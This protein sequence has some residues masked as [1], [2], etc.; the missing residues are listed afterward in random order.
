MS[1]R[2]EHAC[3]RLFE[4]YGVAIVGGQL[5]AL[6]E[7]I[8][9]G[10]SERCGSWGQSPGDRPGRSTKYPCAELH[11]VAIG[12][13]TA[14]AVWCSVEKVILSFAPI[15]CDRKQIGVPMKAALGEVA[16]WV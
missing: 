6:E 9:A 2:V 4:R 5:R 16:R 8:A 11:E 7:E 15:A 14:I 10:K 1:R 3:A 12:R 13:R